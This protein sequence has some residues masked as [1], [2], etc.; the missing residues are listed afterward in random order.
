MHCCGVIFAMKHKPTKGLFA[1]GCLLIRLHLDL[2]LWALP[3]LLA[4]QRA[5]LLA[6]DS[7]DLPRLAVRLTVS[8]G[9]LLYLPPPAKLALYHPHLTETI[10]PPATFPR[11]RSSLQIAAKSSNPRLVTR[12]DIYRRLILGPRA[13]LIVSCAPLLKRLSPSGFLGAP[14]YMVKIQTPSPTSL[15]EDSLTTGSLLANQPA[16]GWEA[17]GAQMAPAPPRIAGFGWS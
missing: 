6:G 5:R 17:P 8:L 11:N 4:C 13:S 7:F 10:P 14:V 16:A 3:E 9:G 15:T 12:V 1:Q 2:A